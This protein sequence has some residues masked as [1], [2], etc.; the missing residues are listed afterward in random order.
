MTC[1]SY[2]ND[3]CSCCI[4]R[5]LYSKSKW[6]SFLS[7]IRQKQQQQQQQNNNNEISSKCF[8][9]ADILTTLNNIICIKQAFYYMEN[10]SS[11]GCI[12]PTCINE[13]EVKLINAI[14]S[15]LLN[16]INKMIN[17]LKE[18]SSG[19]GNGIKSSISSS[20]SSLFKI[21]S[22]NNTTATVIETETETN[23]TEDNLILSKSSRNLLLFLKT[24]MDYLSDII[25]TWFV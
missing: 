18:D 7:N 2:A 14:A 19:G 10:D 21:I 22:S 4:S 16:E 23:G 12:S 9:E 6:K 20:K 3:A 25:Y 1:K 15:A 5:L 8:I 13:V 17:E 24:N 11:S